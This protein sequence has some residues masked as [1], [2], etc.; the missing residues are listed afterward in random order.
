[1]NNADPQNDLIALIVVGRGKFVNAFILDTEAFI[2]G[3]PSWEDRSKPIYFTVD[4]KV[5]ILFKVSKNPYSLSLF[6]KA[7]MSSLCSDTVVDVNSTSSMIAVTLL[8]CLFGIEFINFAI[9]FV[10]A[11]GLDLQPWGSLKYWYD[12]APG[13]AHTVVY[14]LDSG[15]SRRL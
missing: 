11:A 14:F 15:C 2:V 5:S 1:M 8:L 3:L 6:K 7:V 12:C 4:L 10:N 13:E 9:I